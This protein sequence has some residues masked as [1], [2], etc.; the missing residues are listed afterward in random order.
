MLKLLPLIARNNESLKKART[1]FSVIP[2]MSESIA[3]N[4]KFL[5]YKKELDESTGERIPYD[6][7]SF[8]IKDVTRAMLE[9][10]ISISR[11]GEAERFA[12]PFLSKNLLFSEN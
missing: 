10:C 4:E 7:K 5:S 3:I 11:E 2:H 9:A 12:E 1:Q 6:L 8:F